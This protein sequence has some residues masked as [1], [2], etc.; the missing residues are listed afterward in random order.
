MNI[1]LTFLNCQVINA[2]F[3]KM[4]K[5]AKVIMANSQ[6]LFRNCQISTNSNNSPRMMRIKEMAIIDRKGVKYD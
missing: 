3:S 4:A 5:E 6:M 2:D 1:F